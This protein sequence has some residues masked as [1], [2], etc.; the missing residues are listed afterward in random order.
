MAI[1][2]LDTSVIVD[3]MNDRRN[4]RCN[5][6]ALAHGLGVDDRQQQALSHAGTAVVSDARIA[7]TFERGFDLEENALERRGV[8]ERTK[9]LGMTASGRILAVVFT[10]RGD[11]AMRSGGNR[12]TVLWR[13]QE[14]SIERRRA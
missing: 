8:E 12:Y 3:A 4:R 14:L 6:V 10:L 9:T 11:A 2:L 1:Y 5:S 13:L 7:L